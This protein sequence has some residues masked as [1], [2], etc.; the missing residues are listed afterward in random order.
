MRSN[1][2]KE[3]LDFEKTKEKALNLLEYRAHSRKELFDKLKR[4]SDYNTVNEVLDILED[5]GLI[6]DSVFAYEFAHDEIELKYYGPIRITMDLMVKG[7]DRN[8]AEEA[9]E[10]AQEELPDESER[11]SYLLS[12]KYSNI[13][14]EKNG[15]KRTISGLMRMGYSYGL[16]KEAV[17]NLEIELEDETYE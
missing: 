5:G 17:R 10:K 14:K 8:T 6:D 7:I 15:I 2:Q 12:T 9:I 4:V 1:F 13:L 3:K 11:V 16:V